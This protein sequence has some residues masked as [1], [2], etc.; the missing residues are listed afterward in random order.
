[1]PPA[2]VQIG[3]QVAPQFDLLSLKHT[4]VKVRPFIVRPS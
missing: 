2:L 4:D 3:K 1:V